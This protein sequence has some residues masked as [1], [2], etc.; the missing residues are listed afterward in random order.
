MRGNSRHLWLCFALVAVLLTGCEQQLN[1]PTPTILSLNPASI[2]AGQPGFDL[3]VTGKNFTPASTVLWNGSPRTTIFNGTTSLTAQI[4]STDI[5][6]AGAAM[7]EV[8]TPQPG[9]GTTTTLTFTIKAI[10]SPVPQISSL[11]PSG[12]F[13]GATSLTLTVNG[14]NFAS[15]ATVTVNGNP[16]P[17]SFVNSTSLAAS[18]LESD[19]AQAGTLQVVVINPQPNGG[20]SNAIGFAV[21][22]P[23]PGVSS[24]S[25]TAAAAGSA[26]TTLT[27]TG[28]SFVPTSVVTINGSPRTTVFA[29]ATSLQATLTSGDLAAAGVY[30]VAVAN[31][32][33]GGGNSN[34]VTFAVNGSPTGGL[35]VILDLAP[36][37]TQGNDGICGASCNGVPTLQTAGPSANQ[38]GTFV[39]FASDSTNLVLNQKNAVS[40][41]FVRSTCLIAAGTSTSTG[42]SCSPKTFK[43]TQ[44]VNGT[45][46]NGPSSQ[47]SIDSA[48]AHV[49]YTSTA[50][51]LETYAPVSA[52]QQAYW[53]QTCASTSTTSTTASGCTGSTALPALISVSADGTTA[54]NGDSYDPVIS[55]DGQYV[56]FVSLATNLVSGAS[57]DGLTPQV[58]VR[59]TCN[60]V[61]PATGSCTPTTYLVSVDPTGNPSNA[62]SSAPSI[63]NDGLFVAFVSSAT[64]LLAGS[65]NGLTGNSQVFV[66]ST[67]VTTINT[68]GNTCVPAT[69][70]ASTPDGTTPANAASIEPSISGD[71]RFVAFASPATNLI[72]GVPV[73]ATQEIYLR[74]TCTET[75]TT[76]VASC[77][78]STQL[79]STPDA[80]MG[81][82][83]N[84]PCTPAN[85]PS[86]DPS[87][88][89]SCATSST[90]PC[91]TGQYVSFAS[92]ASNLGAN[93][94][95]GV[96]N[97]FSRDT[98]N[99][100]QNIVQTV[101]TL[102]AP[103]TFLSSQ[104]GGTNP[105][106]ANGGSSM[107]AIS[108]DGHSVSF[109]S[110]ASNLVANDTNA[111]ADVFLGPTN[112]LVNLT[113][114]L[115]GAGSGSVTDGTSQISCTQTAA[116]STTPLT[117]SGT[118][119]GKY[120]SGTT[121]TLTATAVTGFTFTGWG[122]SATNVT[123]A[124]CTVTTD[125][126]TTGTCTFSLIADQNATATFK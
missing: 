15:L 110:S 95:N 26:G 14:T 62:A 24:V 68:T 118:C 92:F 61:P 28:V 105:P 41:I 4:L 25:P 84:T 36:D 18:L 34:T 52:H 56:A 33:P 107:P 21:K 11:S 39:A 74:D 13:V 27:V 117:E 75:S 40:N 111:V 48:G 67:C 50:T 72:P 103:Y 80:T 7:I 102:C 77:T 16:R 126:T 65:N 2:S 108:G 69:A 64:N 38:D 57:V 119:T 20:A 73:P 42:S 31:P 70:L 23:T 66:R 116:T 82:S 45:D 60:V 51:N 113:V 90:I 49:A 79:I 22:N 83:A 46:A 3:T 125:S 115:Q 5:Q 112:Q 100:V 9:G 10:S 47:P 123:N 96:E 58:Y 76:V 120:V 121:I 43:I 109:V 91:A 104:P 106:A 85:G 44:A 114:A 93:V 19:L 54:G 29:S 81:C 59:N 98:C 63:A 37:A 1:Y 35:P 6:N 122:G 71:G 32:S 53:Q 88:N 89:S 12:T 97:I 8:T 86:E 99:G 30:P 78:P 101:T 94:Q 87:V 55:S 17:T 124:S